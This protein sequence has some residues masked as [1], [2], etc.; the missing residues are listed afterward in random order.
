MAKSMVLKHDCTSATPRNLIESKKP[1]DLSP[2]QYTLLTSH[3]YAVYGEVIIIAF[4]G[5]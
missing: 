2:E 3:L 1:P 4:R 5:F